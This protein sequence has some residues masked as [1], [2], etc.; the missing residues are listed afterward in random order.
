MPTPCEV[1]VSWVEKRRARE[2]SLRCLNHLRLYLGTAEDTERARDKN[3]VQ[4]DSCMRQVAI[5]LAIFLFA[6]AS[7]CGGQ[8]NQL[9][10]TWKLDHSGAA[11]SP[12]CL[13]PLVFT[14]KTQT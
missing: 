4:E 6:G 12:Y 10:G 2:D 1:Q 9:I 11:Q 13:S 8:A 5:A 14:A 7:A 3:K